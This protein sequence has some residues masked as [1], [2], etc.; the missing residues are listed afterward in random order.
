MKTLFFLIFHLL[1]RSLF[2]QEVLLFENP[3][4]EISIDNLDLVS[5][6]TRDQIFASTGS[7]DVLLFDKSGKQ[8]NLFSPPRQARIQQLEASWTVNI[9]TFSADLQEYRVMD[10]FL[11]PIAENSFLLNNI[12]LPKAATLGNNNIVWV[13]DESDL[14]LKSLDYLRNIILQSQP[15][16]LILDSEE[17]RVTEI[18]EFKN[19]LFM[20]VP[21]SGI[22]IFDNQGNFLQK[23]SIQIEQRMCFY[24][25]Q[26]FWIEGERL[27]MYSL[28]TKAIFD[29][30]KLPTSDIE[31]IQ[32]GQ[33]IMTLRSEDK[34]KVYPIPEGMKRIK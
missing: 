10:R 28:A 34:I 27:K 30:G 31:S 17:L 25:E 33:E 12:T 15:L 16:N 29:L 14:S 7:G 20:N 24:K 23:V 3:I 4:S 32:I 21:E 22:Y 11:N 8:L 2:S 18:R 5:L 9:F 1:S 6:D 19:R 13:W 26:L